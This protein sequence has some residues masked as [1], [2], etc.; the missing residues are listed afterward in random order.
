MIFD[1]ERKRKRRDKLSPKKEILILIIIKIII[2]IIKI[3]IRWH[4]D[5]YNHF[6]GSKKGIIVEFFD[7]QHG[8][9][10]L[11][12]KKEIKSF[13]RKELLL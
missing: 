3:I 5:D 2:V 10:L 1:G 7:V 9:D 13:K 11:L 8:P 4:Y 6:F 12:P